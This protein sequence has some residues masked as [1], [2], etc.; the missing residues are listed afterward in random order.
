MAYLRL[1]LLFLLVAF[2]AAN[3]DIV[4]N[5]DLVRGRGS[6]GRASDS[7]VYSFVVPN[8]PI[9]GMDPAGRDPASRSRGI[10][11]DLDNRVG[12]DPAGRRPG[13][14]HRPGGSGRPSDEYEVP[15]EDKE[16]QPCSEKN[17]QLPNC[18]CSGTRVPKDLP[19]ETIPQFIMLTF[20]DSINPNVAA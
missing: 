17:C 15:D 10:I 12:E 11:E 18:F 8:D 9:Q 14:G 6:V 4:R 19:A 3:H 7:P 13:S 1:S 20:D 16:A 2:A 5:L